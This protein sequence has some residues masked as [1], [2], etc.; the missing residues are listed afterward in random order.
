MISRWGRALRDLLHA[1]G[2]LLDGLRAQSAIDHRGREP[3]AAGARHIARVG[4]K[5]LV[6]PGAQALGEV[7]ST[8]LRWAV[9]DTHRRETSR[10]VRPP[11]ACSARSRQLGATRSRGTGGGGRWGVHGEGCRRP[12][13]APARVPIGHSS[14]GSAVR[15]VVRGNPLAGGRPR[16]AARSPVRG[17]RHRY[18]RAPLDQSLSW[19]PEAIFAAAIEYGARIGPV[20]SRGS[21]A[22]APLNRPRTRELLRPRPEARPS[23]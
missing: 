4:R 5:Q 1:G 23:S 21:R 22:A 17:E 16:R 19:P 7:D 10:A 20:T 8:S 15:P 9:L 3:V 2:H 12:I 13:S 14:H 11:A 18:A 6:E